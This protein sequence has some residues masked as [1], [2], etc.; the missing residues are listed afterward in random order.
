M[1][2]LDYSGGGFGG[3]DLSGLGGGGGGAAVPCFLKGTK[4]NVNKNISIPIE[5]LEAGQ[6]I[7]TEDGEKC[8]RWIAHVFMNYE[9]LLF[10]PEHLPVV[11]ESG[12]LTGNSPT[13]KLITSPNHFLLV[14]GTLVTAKSLINGKNI[15]RDKLENYENGLTYYH[16]EFDSVMLTLS[17]GVFT[18]SYYDCG[19]VF[20]FDNA[21]ERPLDLVSKNSSDLVSEL[22]KS[23]TA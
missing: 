10:F 12:S 1:A 20:L 9:E 7:I 22:E 13:E 18:S 3:F 4:I 17:H 2:F 21:H 5:K 14:N 6:Y 8:V 19:N 16:I 23:I 15:N 11:F